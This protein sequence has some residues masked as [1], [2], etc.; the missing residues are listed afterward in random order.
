MDK[1]TLSNYGWI[2]ICVLVL[3]VMLALASPFGSFVAVGV[4]STTAG[5]FETNQKALNTTGLMSIDDQNFDDGTIPLGGTYTT[6]EGTVLSGNSNDSFPET[7]ATGDTYEYGDY[8]YKY[9]CYYWPSDWVKNTFQ[10]GWGV[11]VKDTSKSSYGEILSEIVGKPVTNMR[12]TFDSCTSLTTAPAIPDSV[13]SMTYTFAGC[14][15]LTKAP[16]IPNGVTNM[17]YT[18][19]RCTSL[20]TAPEIPN[21]VT[22]IN[23]TFWN[24][25]S[26][27]VA[28][29]IPNS[30]TKIS[31]TFKDCTSLT[32]APSIPNSI[33]SIQS[34]FEGCTSLT[35][36]P[37]IPNRVTDMQGTFAYCT[38]LTTAPTIPSK[39][40]NMYCTFKGCTSLS[41]AP[42]IPS[43]VTNMYC[44]FDGCINLTT[45]PTIPSSVTQMGGT[46]RGCTSLTDTI[47]I[48][49]NKLTN[50]DC[51]NCF[52]LGSIGK[53]ITLAGTSTK[54]QMLANTS[55]AGK[56]TV[57]DIN[58][59]I[60]KQ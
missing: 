60:L 5:L 47:T 34:A 54:L 21:R 17:S 36:A 50:Y 56:R 30:V 8:I 23:G 39:V 1:E 14:T 9:N 32:T 38:S 7:P 13:T 46:F 4:K 53:D 37:T 57:Y 25:T 11:R 51:T 41:T 18:F 52:S 2:V 31:Y 22:S 45:A 42:A 26:L 24:C 49:T 3:A 48:N 6:S 55:T 58:G 28:P 20:T 10:N 29:V 12:S 44:T 40:T 35:T 43:C 33:T 16:T 15:K 19:N 59:N 27:K